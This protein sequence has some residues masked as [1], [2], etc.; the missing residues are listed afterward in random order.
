MQEDAGNGEEGQSLLDDGELPPGP[1]FTILCS[2][3]V[4]SQPTFTG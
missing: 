4:T 1:Q 3:T 2:H